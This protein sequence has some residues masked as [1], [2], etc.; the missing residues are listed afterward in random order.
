MKINLRQNLIRLGIL[1]VIFIAAFALFYIRSEEITFTEASDQVTS[2]STVLPLITFEVNGNEI[3]L[4]KGYSVNR[5][6]KV[7]RSTVTPLSNKKELKIYIDEQG[8]KVKKIEAALLSIDGQTEYEKHDTQVFEVTEAGRKYMPVTLNAKMNP[9]DEYLLRV[10]LLNSD[11]NALYYYTRVMVSN[12]GSLTSYNQFVNNFHESSY[13]KDKVN[14]LRIYMETDDDRAL[15]NYAHINIKS[16]LDALSYGDMAP[17]E[18]Y[19]TVTCFSEYNENYV[20]AYVDYN[21]RA[22]TTKGLEYFD[23]REEFRIRYGEK[24]CYLVDFDRYIDT[25][26][27]GDYLSSENYF[28]LGITNH[29]ATEELYSESQEQLLFIRSGT[30]YHLDLK[31]NKLTA[32]HSFYNTNNHAKNGLQ[33]YE[34]KLLD[35]DNEGNASFAVYGYMGKGVY[36]GRMGVVYY[37]YNADTRVLTERMFIPLDLELAE[38]RDKIFNISFLDE[39]SVFYFNIYDALYSYQVD[40]N[41][42]SLITEDMGPNWLYFEDSKTVVYS[43]NP[44]PS[45]NNKL[46]VRNLLERKEIEIKCESGQAISLFGTVDGRIVYGLSL[47][48]KSGKF[49]NGKTLV[50]YTSLVIAD[51]TGWRYKVVD[52]P[53]GRYIS[54]V[55]LEKGIISYSIY[56]KSSRDDEPGY[57]VYDSVGKD[58]II[59]QTVA[60]DKN[61]NYI[62]KLLEI[63]KT[64]Y[65]MK[66]P[67]FYKAENPPKLYTTTYKVITKETQAIIPEPKLNSFYASCYGKIVAAGEDLGTVITAAQKN[68]GVVLDHAGNVVWVKGDYIADRELKITWMPTDQTGS[69]ERSIAGMVAKLKNIELKEKFYKT[70]ICFI[71]Y[72]KKNISPNATYI[73]GADINDLVNF[74]SDGYPVAASYKNYM[75]LVYSYNKSNIAAYDPVAKKVIRMTKEEAQRAFK[76]AGGFFYVFY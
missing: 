22:N 67:S 29:Q 44:D 46:V 62:S 42:L 37:N 10:T 39:A 24:R 49:N 3:N 9:S 13:D 43:K 53:E 64:E 68:S 27:Q 73:T 4:T 52:S 63:T 76:Q 33:E 58:V 54:N 2:Q 32:V 23:A 38:M 45:V 47:R 7:N 1:L 56:K 15:S 31:A 41:T 6:T 26:F 36:E 5:D 40:T 57:P 17:I 55:S 50:P 75:I 25:V 21:F 48:D 34:Y 16:S 30:L 72:L 66:L 8:Q 65:Y 12:F 74:I 14:D 60:S 20:Y 61:N 71:D 35:F 18:N 51:L 69:I 28:K 59:N 70:N 11:G 19:R